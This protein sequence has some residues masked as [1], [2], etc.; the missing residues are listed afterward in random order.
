METSGMATDDPSVTTRCAAWAET[1][2][3]PP[4]TIPCMTTTIGF[5]YSDIIRFSAYSSRQKSTGARS[6][7]R[8]AL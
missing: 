1:P 4:I 5:E 3:P 6:P 8:A 7:E 2:T